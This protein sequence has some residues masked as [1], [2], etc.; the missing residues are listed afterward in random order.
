MLT[1]ETVR[2]AIA[3]GRKSECIDGRDYNRLLR[4]F[5]LEEWPLLGFEAK[6]DIERPAVEAWTREAV[7]G[8]LR[9]DVAFGFEK[10]L[11]RRGLSAGAMYGV[12]RMWLWILEDP[13]AA[14][15]DSDSDS[16]SLYGFYGL[17]LLKLVAVQFGFPN[18]VGDDTG[19]EEK[20][21]ER[22]GA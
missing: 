12:V 5:P 18:P 21:A 17:P 7:T 3:A 13:L 11:D 20:Y 6:E 10:A 15:S 16:D 4:F 1:R 8:R 2:D 9:A 19:T 22:H 14:A